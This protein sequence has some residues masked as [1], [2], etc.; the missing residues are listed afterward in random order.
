ML[1]CLPSQPDPFG[2]ASSP[3]VGA[4][5]SPCKVHLSARFS[6]FGRGV[7]EGGG[8]VEVIYLRKKFIVDAKS[9]DEQH[10]DRQHIGQVAA[11]PVLHFE[12][13][14]GVDFLFIVVPALSLI[15]I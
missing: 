3:K 1:T 15:H 6:P 7:T 5:D 13:S 12:A 2:F 4:F 8:E 14:A 10:N 9:K 11:H